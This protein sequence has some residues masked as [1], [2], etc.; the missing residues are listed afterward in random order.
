MCD[1]SLEGMKSV[2][3]VAGQKYVLD[4]RFTHGFMTGLPVAGSPTYPTLACVSHGQTLA[5]TEVVGR[6][7]YADVPVSC[8]VKVISRREMPN[9]YHHFGSYNDGIELLDGRSFPIAYLMHAVMEV[10]PAE[11]P[12][13]DLD[14]ALG[15]NEIKVPDQRELVDGD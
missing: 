13:I 9:Q 2:K 15:L 8:T 12:K 7:G 1:Y 14:E 5:L 3:A 11:A 10:V 4:G 6:K